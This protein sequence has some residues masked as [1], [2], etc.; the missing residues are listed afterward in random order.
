[1]CYAEGI[2]WI[3]QGCKCGQNISRWK[4]TKVDLQSTLL[5]YCQAHDQTVIECDYLGSS[6]HKLFY[7]PQVNSTVIP[8]YKNREKRIFEFSDRFNPPHW[9]PIFEKITI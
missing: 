5:S 3:E 6:Y 8:I 4:V 2:Q 9:P 1:M 7:D